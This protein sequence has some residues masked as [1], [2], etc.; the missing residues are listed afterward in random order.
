MP[1]IVSY[2]IGVTRSH[3]PGP[4]RW[5]TLK[6]EHDNDGA[7]SVTMFFYEKDTPAFGFLNPETRNL[8]VNL[9]ALD[10]DPT[11]RILQT[12]KPVYAHYRVHGAEHRLLS[13]DISTSEEPL[14]EGPV[15]RSP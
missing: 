8:V 2:K 1:A 15:D 9:P 3:N 5:L 13:I 4:T 14:G 12:E 7:H 11:S 10:F 6:L